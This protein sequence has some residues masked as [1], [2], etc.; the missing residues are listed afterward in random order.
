M[1]FRL[2]DLW[3][4]GFWTFEVPVDDVAVMVGVV[5]WEELDAVG[6]GEVQWHVSR[7]DRQRWVG[8]VDG[9][10]VGE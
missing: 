3:K 5:E 2:D 1:C 6:G 10:G 8:G 9:E 4:S 7:F